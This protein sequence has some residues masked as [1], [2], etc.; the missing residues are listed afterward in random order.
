[1]DRLAPEL[2]GSRRSQVLAGMALALVLGSLIAG[3]VI[4]AS[5]Q[6]AEKGL[7]QVEFFSIEQFGAAPGG[8]IVYYPE[9]TTFVLRTWLMDPLNGR[10]IYQLW[11]YED[12]NS[13]PRVR[14]LALTDA[15]AFVGLS[16]VGRGDLSRVKN[17]FVTVEP[18]GGSEQ[19]TGEP[20]IIMVER[21]GF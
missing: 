13:G 6:S 8:R 1:M 4:G 9:I 7:S 11:L 20:I 16:V 21:M 17:L 12:T 3:T 10:G 18:P 5:R 14:S 19:P 15:Q 2:Q